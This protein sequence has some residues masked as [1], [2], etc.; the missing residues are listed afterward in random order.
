MDLRALL[1]AD[2]RPAQ[3]IQ[4]VERAARLDTPTGDVR[5]DATLAAGGAT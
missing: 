2:G 3:A 1:V 5:D 4:P